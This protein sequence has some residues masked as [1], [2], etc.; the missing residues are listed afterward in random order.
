MCTGNNFTERHD[1]IEWKR[2]VPSNLTN[3]AFPKI[4]FLLILATKHLQLIPSPPPHLTVYIPESCSPLTFLVGLVTLQY[5]SIHH[6]IIIHTSYSHVS[7][8]WKKFIN[9]T[10]GIVTMTNSVESVSRK[11]SRTFNI[12]SLSFSN[13]S[14][15]T[16]KYNKCEHI[17]MKLRN[18]N[19]RWK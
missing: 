18:S 6:Y 19:P 13:L 17:K 5:M 7:Q 16:I 12:L 8:L 15:C 3:M 4:Y 2:V 9:H 14:A 10:V 1:I 11:S